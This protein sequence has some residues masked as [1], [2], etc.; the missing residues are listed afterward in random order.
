GPGSGKGTQCAN[1]V[2]HCGYTLLSAGEWRR[3]V[4]AHAGDGNFHTVIL[5]DP[6]YDDQRK[7]AERFNNFMVQAAL[8]MEGTCTEV[9]GAG[10]GKVKYQSD[11]LANPSTEILRLR[12]PPRAT[13]GGLLSHARGL[14]FKPRREGFPSGAKNEWGLSPKAKVQVLHT[15]QLDVTRSKHFS[16]KPSESLLVLQ[17]GKTLLRA[18]GIMIKEIDGLML[19]TIEL[20]IQRNLEPLYAHEMLKEL[21]TMFAQQAEQELLQ[22]TRDFHSCR[23]EEWQSV[24][25]YVLK[26]KGDINNLERLGHPVTLGLGVSLIL[27][28]L[29]KEYD[30]F[31]QNYNT[32]NMGKTVNELHAM[33]KLHEQTLP[34]SNAPALNDIRAGKVQKASG[35]GG[36]GI[37]VIELNTILNRSW[38]YDTGCGTHICNTTQGLRASRKLKPRALS[39]YV[40]NGQRK[41]VEAIGAFYLCIHSGLKIVLNNCHY[42]PCITRGVIFVSRLYEDG[43]VNRFVDNAIQVSRNNV[44]YFCAIPR[45]GIF[46]IDLSNSLTNKS[47]VYAVSNKRAKLDL[48]FALMAFEKC[49]SYMYGKMKRKPYIHQVERAKDLLG[50]IHTDDHRIIAHRTPTYTPQHN[51]VS[52]RRNRTLLDMVRSMISQTTLPKSFWDYALETAARMLNMVPT[53]KVEKTPY[54]IKNQVH[55]S[56]DTSLNHKEDDLEIDE[57]QSD[58][59]LIRRSTRTRHAP[60]RMC[61]YIDAEENELEDLGEPAN[62]KAALLDPE[63][64]KWLNAMNVEMQ[65]MKDNEVWVLV[66]LPPNGKTVGSMWLFKKKTDMD[67][68]VHIYKA[69]LVA[70][71]Y[72]QTPRIDYEKTFSPVADRRA[73]RIPIAIA[74]YYDYEIWKMDV[75]TAFLNG[76]LNEEVYMKQPEGFVNP[77]YQNRVC[78]LKCSMYGLKQASRQWNKRFDNEI[79]RFGFIQNRDK[80]LY[81]KR[82]VGVISLS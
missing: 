44:V 46:E 9:H 7:E 47:F 61:L 43:F 14:G 11:L 55:P 81:I 25:L 64:E 65:S 3:T 51:G 26:M 70:K 20:E 72:T 17:L 22:T 32:H 76:Y 13:L 12:W 48:D 75:K 71:G 4:I 63:S 37:F 28:G 54:E 80:P 36:S 15:A 19:M 67:R 79:K 33:L 78:K 56:L 59:V 24:S 69:R 30:G 10:T 52:E 8:S 45:D 18:R 66:E 2:E 5:F 57:P 49:V 40:G 41:A 35:A 6:A 27:I 68:N 62:Y 1:I 53:K 60:D 39:L 34:K 74:A 42:A 73:I 38:I 23:Q 50:L 21:K 29:R 31:V 58:I 82:L 16:R 77:K